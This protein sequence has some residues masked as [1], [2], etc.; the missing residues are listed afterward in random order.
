MIQN[1]ISKGMG[2]ICKASRSLKE[3]TFVTLY[4]SFIYP[5]LQYG[6]MAWSK[7]TRNYLEPLFLLQKR[8]IRLISFET[9]LAHT[10]PLFKKIS[11]MNL[12]NVYILNI[13]LFMFKF[14][15]GDLPAISGDM[16]SLNS[17][18]HG[19][20]TPLYHSPAWHLEIRRRSIYIRSSL[21]EHS[22]Q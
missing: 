18:I 14:K 4:Y 12:E 16:F 2:L 17:D 19:H 3:I 13:M 5:Y 1:K 22:M 20:F 6:N 21:L 11:L 9:R 8:V 10:A 7:T 15:N